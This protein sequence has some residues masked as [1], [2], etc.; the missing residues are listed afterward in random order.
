[1]A[2]H[3]ILTDETGQEIAKALSVIAQTNIARKDMDW[4]T[5]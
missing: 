5:V 4:P 3:K 1:M 2:K